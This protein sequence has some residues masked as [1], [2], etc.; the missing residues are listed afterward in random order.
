MQQRLSMQQQQLRIS[1]QQQRL[2]QYGVQ[3]DQQQ[4]LATE[5]AAQLQRQN[6]TAQHR[7]QLLYF[8]RLRDQQLAIQNSRSYNYGGDPFFYTPPSYRYSRDGRD[9]ETNSYG[10]TVLGQAVNNGYQEGFGAGQADQQDHWAF[11]FQD[12]Y[13]YQDGNYGYGGFYIER[14]E[15]NYYFRQGFRRGYDDGYY[16][17]S[18]YGA[19]SAGTYTVLGPELSV[20]LNLQPLP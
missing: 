19:Y 5:Q 18:Q 14:D 9:Y 12:S 13:A 17:R 7:F 4:R 16:G 6:R 20:I 3:L 1:Q 8:A 11:N 2:L 10:A 15:Y